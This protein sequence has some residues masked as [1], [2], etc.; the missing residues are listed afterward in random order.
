MEKLK[1]LWSNMSKKA[2]Y[3]VIGI[4]VFL[5]LS[6]FSVDCGGNSTEQVAPAVV[7]ELTLKPAQT[8]IKGDLKG[9]YEVVDKNYKVKFATKSYERDI[10]TVELKRTDKQLPYDRKNVVIFPEAKESTAENCA[11]FGIEILNADGDVID[12]VN[13]NATPYSWD[14]MTA[15]L[16]L[17]TDDTTT[18]DFRFESLDEA[19]S[20]RVTSIVMENE[21][22]K[23]AETKKTEK[24]AKKAEKDDEGSV[25]KSLTN[26]AKEAIDL[27]ADDDLEQLEKDAETALK[28]ADK[29]MKLAGK[30][31][32]VLK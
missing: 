29:T 20:F 1:E 19:A 15:A 22:L 11:G 7:K 26:L 31:L 23:K 14:E 13:A 5:L 25:L 9:C 16:Q 27:D 6:L 3:I 8:E 30:M 28:V 10:I 17:V 18:I 12:K 21:E 24:E 2:R 4:G 32:D